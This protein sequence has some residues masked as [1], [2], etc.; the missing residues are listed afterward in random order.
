MDVSMFR[1][2]LDHLPKYDLPNGY[3]MRR[4]Q[5]G[6]ISHWLDF[7]IPLF[8]D[9]VIDEALFWHEF[10]QDKG[11]LAERQYYMVHGKRVIGSISSWF[12]SEERGTHLGRIH[13][14]VLDE[15]YRGKGLSKPLLSF[16]CHRLKQL[17]HKQAYL[18]T[19]TDLIPAIGLYLKFGFEPEI[20][21]DVEKLAWDNVYQQL[22]L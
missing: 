5:P 18:S 1:L 7:H 4:H 17:G 3:S 20:K 9:G 11:I 22:D 16:A 8:E 2:N 15:D 21:S 19:H 12:G 14:V 13:W 6:D 10:G